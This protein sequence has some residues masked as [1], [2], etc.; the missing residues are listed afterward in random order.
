MIISPIH[1]V[2]SLWP[3]GICMKQKTEDQEVSKNIHAKNAAAE[4]CSA[5][6]AG[7]AASG[8]APQLGAGLWLL[9]VVF[10]GVVTIKLS[11]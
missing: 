7:S 2:V 1:F 11:F 3:C 6:N 4:V 9:Y 8:G 5:G 10:K